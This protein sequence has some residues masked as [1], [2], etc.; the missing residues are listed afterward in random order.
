MERLTKEQLEKLHA[1]RAIFDQLSRADIESLFATIHALTSECDAL[2]A[3]SEI[4]FAIGKER[5]RT[6]LRQ[7][8][9]AGQAIDEYGNPRFGSWDSYESHLAEEAEHAARM[10]RIAEAEEKEEL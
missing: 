4:N 3:A 5:E 6:A 1:R 2:E 10:V 7:G 9:E 8:F